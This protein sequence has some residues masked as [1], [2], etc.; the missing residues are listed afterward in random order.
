MVAAIEPEFPAMETADI[1]LL[2]V[3]RVLRHNKVSCYTAF[4]H[5]F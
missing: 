3:V 1:R 4:H 2:T 5:L